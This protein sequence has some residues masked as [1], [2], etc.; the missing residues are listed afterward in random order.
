MKTPK[1][2]PLEALAPLT[3]N[4]KPSTGTRAAAQMSLPLWP[5]EMRGVPNAVLRGALFSVTQRRENFRK[6]T[7]L[8]IVDDIEIRY[9]GERLNQTDLDVWE[10][11]LHLARLQP[12]SHQVEFSINALL[13]ELDRKTGKAQHDQLHEELTRLRAGTVDMRNS[14]GQRVFGGLILRGARDEVTGRYVVELD[15]DLLRMYQAGYSHIDWQQR[16][17]LGSNNLAKWLHGFYSTH[18]TP[19]PYKVETICSLSGSTVGRI[20]DFRR[21]LRTALGQLVDVGAIT[22]WD[23]DTDDLVTV[24]R[25]PLTSQKRHLAKKAGPRHLTHKAAPKRLAK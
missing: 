23:I 2:S 14:A 4:R 12:L 25:A 5:N 21:M 13:R 15:P 17:A 8:T 16:L 1:T 20:V 3:A 10:A 7:L 22:G 18:A 9:K 24:E 6:L 19:Y 11:L